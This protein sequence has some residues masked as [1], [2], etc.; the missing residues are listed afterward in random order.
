MLHF[1]LKAYYP[2][3]VVIIPRQCHSH[4][5][6]TCYPEEHFFFR[7]FTYLFFPVSLSSVL[8]Y[9]SIIPSFI[10]F[11]SVL[12]LSFLSLPSF[13]FLSYIPSFHLSFFYLSF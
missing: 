1:A 8:P 4:F 3:T 13:L 2:G 7:F 11:P 5:L 10:I 6:Q 12:C 9:V